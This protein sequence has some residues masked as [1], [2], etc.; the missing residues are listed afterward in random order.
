MLDYNI[1]FL[2]TINQNY[3]KMDC[4][5]SLYYSSNE[6]FTDLFSCFDF[7]D[8]DVF[9]IVG[10]G[11]QALYFYNRG[12]RQVDLFDINIISIYYYYLRLWSIK[13]LGDLYPMISISYI[14]NVLS[15]VKPSDSKEEN[16]YNYWKKLINYYEHDY[17]LQSLFFFGN[18]SLPLYQRIYD[19]HKLNGIISS[20][21]INYTPMDI[22][23]PVNM[24]EKY[25]I[26]FVSNLSEYI[27]SA[28]S[29]RIYS[30]NL[31]I[32][33]KHDGIVIASNIMEEGPWDTERR[34][35][36]NNFDYHNINRGYY[37]TKKR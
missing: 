32:L 33:L 4:Y 19:V 5:S 14:N 13:Y 17:E 35:L 36:F 3:N 18:S 21:C 20:K 9:S 23:N 1:D 31:D 24:S 26:I 8:K 27:T 28:K 37:Y 30:K 22:T 12:C 2:N 29:F 6:N 25:D 10:S 15:K 11:D 34:I 7:K 16:A